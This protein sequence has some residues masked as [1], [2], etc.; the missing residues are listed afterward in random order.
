MTVWQPSVTLIEL[1]GNLGRGF[2]IACA[3]L[4]IG[5]ACRLA[6]KTMENDNG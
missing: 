1:A 6:A 4:L 3:A 2:L 5:A